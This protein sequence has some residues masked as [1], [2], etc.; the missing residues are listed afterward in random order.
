MIVCGLLFDLVEAFK[1]SNVQKIRLYMQVYLMLQK[2]L[3]LFYLFCTFENI[4]RWKL[5]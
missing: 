5:P 2:M 1:Y 3:Y 4:D